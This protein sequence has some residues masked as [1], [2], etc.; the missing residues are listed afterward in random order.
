ID[1]RPKPEP[2]MSQVPEREQMSHAEQAA[3]RVS[4]AKAKQS[5]ATTVPSPP[6]MPPEV[7]R[8]PR[9]AGSI[10]PVPPGSNGNDDNGEKPRNGSGSIRP[11]RLAMLVGVV[12]VLLVVLGIGTWAVF[13]SGSS[14]PAE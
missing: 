3:R 5:P 12:F 9:S 4:E 11:R 8:R 13:R 14:E 10:P 7:P 1:R 6:A 2:P